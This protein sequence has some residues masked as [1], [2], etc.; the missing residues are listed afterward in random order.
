MEHNF[1]TDQQNN[2]STTE[3]VLSRRWYSMYYVY[4]LLKWVNYSSQNLMTY[5]INGR[6]LDN[7][8]N[9]S[10]K[11]VEHFSKLSMYTLING[12]ILNVWIIRVSL[13]KGNAVCAMDRSKDS[14]IE[15]TNVR[16]PGK[17]WSR[18]FVRASAN[19]WKCLR[20]ERTDW[21]KNRPTLFWRVLR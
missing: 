17:Y 4:S 20:G 14:T 11:C 7:N 15:L 5:I 3:I 21:P 18:S 1:L 9:D 13:W 2:V 6:C 10:H 8:S 16:N 12:M 19:I